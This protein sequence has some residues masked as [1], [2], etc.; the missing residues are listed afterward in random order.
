MESSQA[1]HFVGGGNKVEK[2]TD[3]STDYNVDDENIDE[4]VEASSEAEEGTDYY[5]SKGKIMTV[6]KKRS[7]LG[8]MTEMFKR[9]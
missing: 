4:L 1:I 6:R 9:K 7:L 3:I 5:D 2:D 8:H